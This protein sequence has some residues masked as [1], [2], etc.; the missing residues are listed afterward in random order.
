MSTTVSST[1]V[2]LKDLIRAG[3]NGDQE[4][5]L[6]MNRE[7]YWLILELANFSPTSFDLTSDLG[8]SLKSSASSSKE[9]NQ[10]KVVNRKPTRSPSPV[11]SPNSRLGTPIPPTPLAKP[12]PTRPQASRSTIGY[13]SSPSVPQ[14]TY[15]PPSRSTSNLPTPAERPRVRAFGSFS[16]IPE[17]EISPRVIGTV[18]A[19]ASRVQGLAVAESIRTYAAPVA[20]VLKNIEPVADLLQRLSRAHPIA[21][22]AM[23]AILGVYHLVRAQHESDRAIVSLHNAMVKTYEVAVKHKESLGRDSR[24]N[25]LFKKMVKQADE[26]YVFI[27]EYTRRRYLGRLTRFSVSHKIEEYKEAFEHLEQ[28]FRGAEIDYT[29]VSLLQMRPVI[30]AVDLKNKLER[31]RPPQDPLGPLCHCLHGTRVES[32][33]TIQEWVFRREQSIL[34]LN[35]PAGSG[36]SS[37]MGTLHSRHLEMGFNSRL[38]AFIRFDRDEYKEARMFVRTLAYRLAEFD[39]RLGESIAQRVAA[40]PQIVDDTNLATQLETLVLEP[41]RQHG[42]EMEDEGPVVILIDGLDECTRSDATRTK[43]DEQLLALL[44][45]DVL[46]AF[47]FLRIIIASRPVS[48]IKARFSGKSHIFEFR[49]DIASRENQA[50]IRS[51]IDIRLMD[52]SA[53]SAGFGEVC[54]SVKA[55]DELSKRA[56]GL[57]MWASIAVSFVEAYSP[58]TRLQAIVKTNIPKSALEALYT[59]YRTTLEAIVSESGDDDIK[60]DIRLVLGMIMATSTVS[61]FDPPFTPTVLQN[62]LQHVHENGSQ[63]H[64]VDVPEVL[65]KLASV[66]RHPSEDSGLHLLHVSFAEFLG[67]RERC[68][69]TWYIDDEKYAGM[70]ASACISCVLAHIHEEELSEAPRKEVDYSSWFWIDHCAPLS[71]R[72]V[73][74]TPNL[75]DRLTRMI[76]MDMIRWIRYHIVRQNRIW[77]NWANVDAFE[78]IIADPQVSELPDHASFK[79]LLEDAQMLLSIAFEAW[80]QGGLWVV[81]CFTWLCQHPT[82]DL[83]QCYMPGF[84][85]LAGGSTDY[86]EIVEAIRKNGS[87]RVPLGDIGSFREIEISGIPPASAEPAYY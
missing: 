54:Q 85:E 38:A 71:A 7:D 46:G 70:L 35:G 68:S 79:Q 86:A 22:L 43:F 48:E 69:S 53:K 30:E 59:L 45:S 19:G 2:K 15:P 76:R 80:L 63:T 36:K 3:R 52:I 81:S 20:E 84:V 72:L 57:F 41:L 29:A 33:Q 18:V 16:R 23:L 56:G 77:Q 11:P 66:L 6:P 60:R 62:L 34:W 78:K 27:S 82:S 24:F 28:Q 14:I 12:V 13:D 67:D 50:D 39:R 1:E 10:T 37:L 61:T 31:L 73:A 87:N 25:E 44:E 55:V 47:P 64:D 26:C 42:K 49:L 58:R 17:P 4:I 65:A 75:H 8:R 74:T 83:Y 40:Q 32:L 51:F 21:E 9:S 5:K